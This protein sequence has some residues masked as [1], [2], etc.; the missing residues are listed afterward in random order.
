MTASIRPATSG[1]DRALAALDRATWSAA[2]SPAPV[3][4]PGTAF[5]SERIAPS[6]TLVAERN[7][8]LVGY[9]AFGA[10][11]PLPTNTHVLEIRGLAVAPPARCEGIGRLLIEALQTE[12]RARDV[13]RITLRVLAPNASARALYSRCGFVEEGILRG[14]FLLAGEFVDDVLMA[15]VV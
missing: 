7:D 14:E 9:V 11:T 4:D 6:D 12:A 2:A 1:D 13:R 15:R 5:F 10:P 8:E 3:P